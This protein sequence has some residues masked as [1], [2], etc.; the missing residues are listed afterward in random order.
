MSIKTG[1]SSI[2]ENNKI[3]NGKAGD[4]NSREVCFSTWYNGNWTCVLRPK[5]KDLAEKS[6]KACED[7][8]NNNNIGYDQYQ[9]NTLYQR[10]KEANFDLSKIKV[11]CEC[12]CSSFMHVC[13]IAGGANLKYGSNGFTTR[14]MKNEF[15]KSGDYEILTDKKYLTSDKYLKRGDVLVREGSHTI[16][17]LENGS[18]IVKESNHSDEKIL[19][20]VQI[21]AY[22]VKSNAD[23]FLKKVKKNVPDAFITIINGMYKIQVGAYSIKTN[24]EKQL[25]KMKKLGYS[26]AFITTNT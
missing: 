20:R 11:P 18:E 24:A 2:D 17:A 6:A 16:M 25:E 3:C 5:N 26:D 15:N 22:S 8:C 19:Y 1:H 23:N 12:D 21:G 9:R 14:T 10:A 13:A 7:G 4:Q